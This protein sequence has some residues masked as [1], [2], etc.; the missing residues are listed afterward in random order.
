MS[1]CPTFRDV[2]I[3]Q[4]ARVSHS[5]IIKFLT[6][7][8]LMI[9]VV[10]NNHFLDLLLLMYWIM[11]AFFLLSVK[12]VGWPYFLS[13]YWLLLPFLFFPWIILTR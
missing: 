8:S 4:W 2:N 12:F 13:C 3:E 11:V 10:T 9:L 6:N 1:G 7:L 5:F